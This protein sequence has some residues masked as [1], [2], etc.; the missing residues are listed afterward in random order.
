MSLDEGTRAPKRRLAFEMSDS[1]YKRLLWLMHVCG[2]ESNKDLFNNALTVFEWAAN[3]MA[4]GRSIGV[5]DREKSEFTPLSHAALD[6]AA[7]TIP[8]YRDAVRTDE[9]H[10]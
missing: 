9:I 3:E 6:R 5:I 1:E 2:L 7:K 8:L 4:A 10:K